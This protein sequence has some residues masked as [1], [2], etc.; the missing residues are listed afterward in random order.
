[1]IN[2]LVEEDLTLDRLARAEAKWRYSSQ[3]DWYAHGYYIAI[4]ELLGD[5]KASSSA[6]PSGNPK[7]QKQYEQGY[8]D[9]MGDFDGGS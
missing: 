3:R 4:L 7:F 1:L 5:D 6:A 9:A 2:I 8:A